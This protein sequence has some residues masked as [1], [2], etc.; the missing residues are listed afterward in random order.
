MADFDGNYIQANVT[1]TFIH[2]VNGRRKKKSRK[3][4]VTCCREVHCATDICCLLQPPSSVSFGHVWTTKKENEID[5][6]WGEESNLCVNIG[7][8]TMLYERSLYTMRETNVIGPC[9]SG[10]YT[11]YLSATASSGMF[12][13]QI[14]T[15]HAQAYNTF[16]FR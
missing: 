9:F 14:Y 3:I 4:H 16:I 10:I 12:H 13:S 11:I 7:E 2:L 1:H 6:L 15:T 8:P 5:G